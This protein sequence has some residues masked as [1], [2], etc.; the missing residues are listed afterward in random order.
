MQKKG[1]YVIL[2]AS[3]R[4]DSGMKP[5]IA[6]PETNMRNTRSLLSISLILSGILLSFPLIAKMELPQVTAEGLERVPDTRLA[7]VYAEPDIDLS[8]YSKLLLIEPQVAFRKNW[9]QDINRNLRQTITP[10]DMQN[11][12]TEL[13]A[14]F[15]EILI[16]KLESGNYVLVKEQGEDVLIIRPAI[17]D[18]NVNSPDTPRATTTRSL[19]RSAGD[20]TLYLELRD[21]ITGDILAKALDYQADHSNITTFVRD[22]TRNEQAARRIL[23][24]WAQILLNGLD[25]TMRVASGP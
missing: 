24:E 11:I 18:L 25:E 5:A 3:I 17:L 23:N 20:M 9:R 16:S 21:S 7:V 15:N 14:M 2:P 22:R 8:V 19:S 10:Q 4:S 13:A 1:Q 12:R 6:H